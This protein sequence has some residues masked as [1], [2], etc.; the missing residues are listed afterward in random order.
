MNWELQ[1]RIKSTIERIESKRR[2]SK[3]QH[4]TRL[5]ESQKYDSFLS[6]WYKGDTGQIYLCVILPPQKQESTTTTNGSGEGIK[7]RRARQKLKQL[8]VFR[9]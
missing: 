4:F 2:V 9:P 6:T 1:D 8:K 3:T 7:A 5:T